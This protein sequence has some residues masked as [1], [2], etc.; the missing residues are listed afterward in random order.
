VSSLR[1][2]TLSGY[3]TKDAAPACYGKNIGIFAQPLQSPDK[4]TG[5]EVR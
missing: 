2:I 1:R 5:R 3:L 4:T